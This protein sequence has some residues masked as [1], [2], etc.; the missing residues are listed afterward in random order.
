MI[1]NTNDFMMTTIMSLRNIHVHPSAMA[2][3]PRVE[4]FEEMAPQR[5]KPVYAPSFPFPP[6][7]IPANLDPKVVTNIT[8]NK[9]HSMIIHANFQAD[10]NYEL[11]IR[12][13][14]L[15]NEATEN[16]H[17]TPHNLSFCMA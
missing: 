12:H 9:K 15:T 2:P 3:T 17:L 4:N 10:S 6:A 11:D 5:H 14:C 16:L 8:N 1:D 7:S 13:A